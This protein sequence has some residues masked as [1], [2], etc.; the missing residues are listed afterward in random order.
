MHPF[1]HDIFIVIKCKKLKY[2]FVPQYEGLGIRDIAAFISDHP[3]SHI[4]LPDEKELRRLPK[5]FIV[6]VASTIIGKAFDDWVKQQVT[7]RNLK[8]TKDKD[9]N[10]EVDPEIAEIFRQS[11]S[12]SSKLV[13]LIF[14]YL[15]LFLIVILII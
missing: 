7:T 1:P 6:N 13:C 9:L 12:V 8:I 14:L 2:V 4:Y 5:Q 15:D 10:I 3:E 11:T